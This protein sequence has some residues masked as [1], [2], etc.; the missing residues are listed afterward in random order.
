MAGGLVLMGVLLATLPV[1]DAM[2]LHGITQLIANG[3]RAWLTRRNIETRGV[4]RYLASAVICLAI[5][6]A[7]RPTLERAWIYV[8]VGAMPF[9]AALFPVRARLDFSRPVDSWICGFVVTTAHLTAGVSGPLLD[10][11]F[12]QGRLRAVEVIATKATTQS[13]GHLLKIVYF[14]AIATAGSTVVDRD[15]A[16]SLI[17]VAGVSAIAGTWL[18]RRIGE[19]IDEGSFRTWSR[20]LVL[21]IGAGCLGRGIYLLTANS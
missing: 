15:G 4:A 16:W 18:G 11:F 9:I 10:I 17:G 12:L 20:L 6:F 21:T 19:R 5:A 13:A 8:A 1:P 2:V 7:F 14:G 3:Y